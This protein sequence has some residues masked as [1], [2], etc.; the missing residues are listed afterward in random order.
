MVSWSLSASTLLRVALGIF[1]NA[2]LAGAKTVM[3][4]A[5]L[6]ESTRLAFFTAV[7]SVD[8]TGFPDAAVATGTLAMAAK[9]PGFDASVGTAAQPAPNSSL[10]AMAEP[11]GAIDGAV[12]AAAGA[13]R[14][15]R[16]RPGRPRRHRPR[17]RRCRSGG[18]GDGKFQGT[19]GEPFRNGCCQSGSRLQG[20]RMGH[21]RVTHWRAARR[22]RNGSGHA[23]RRWENRARRR[24]GHCGRRDRAVPQITA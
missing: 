17:A 2:L 9:L 21:V 3:P 11:D 18:R 24:H 22:D 23:G 4:F 15:G 13:E 1:S 16:G 6:S 7:T 19:H 12:G 8:S 14:G 10:A 20:K 5:L